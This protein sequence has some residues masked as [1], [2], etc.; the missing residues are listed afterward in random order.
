MMRPLS[1]APPQPG[2]S[3]PSYPRAAVAIT[4]QCQQQPPLRN[5]PHEPSY[6]YLLIRRANPPDQGKWSLPGGKIHWGESTLDAAKRELWEETKLSENQCHWFPQPFLTTDAIVSAA[7]SSR[8][9]NDNKNDKKNNDIQQEETVAFHYLIAHCFARI[10]VMPMESGLP[11]KLTPSDDA[12]DAKW[13]TLP[14]IK[15]MESENTLSTHVSSVIQR[16]EELSNKGAL[17]STGT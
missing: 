15:A 13:C 10:V 7:S 2:K 6:K 14:E 1:S 3:S 16:A 5:A 4:V 11:P 12:L 9:T 17:E 8:S